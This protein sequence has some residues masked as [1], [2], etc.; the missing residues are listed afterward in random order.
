MGHYHFFCW[1]KTY[2]KIGNPQNDF[3]RVLGLGLTKIATPPSIFNQFCS[4]K[5]FINR[6]LI[7]LPPII[8]L[9]PIQVKLHPTRSKRSVLNVFGVET[10]S[11][12]TVQKKAP[13]SMVYR[14]TWRDL[15]L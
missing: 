9:K 6:L 14:A 3:L 15:K 11:L 5:L 7:L 1:L 10:R 12:L 4:D 13:Y 2:K 8:L